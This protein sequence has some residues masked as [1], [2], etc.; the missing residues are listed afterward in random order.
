MWF[1]GHEHSLQVLCLF[2]FS[3]LA[4]TSC[5]FCSVYWVSTSCQDLYW[6]FPHIS[7]FVFP[8]AFH[9]NTLASC[10][11]RRDW[12]QC[13]RFPD[14]RDEVLPTSSILS[15]E[16]CTGHEST[17]T[18]GVGGRSLSKSWRKQYFKQVCLTQRLV[19][20]HQG[21][22]NSSPL[23]FNSHGVAMAPK[24]R[25]RVAPV[26]MKQISHLSK[27]MNTDGRLFTGMA[28]LLCLWVFVCILTVS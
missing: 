7:Y 2:N 22:F 21:P 23:Y 19:L 15:T 3:W 20:F 8:G 18:L 26:L 10:H 28:E 4:L 25:H 6:A 13:L 14:C 11:R 1:T 16:P 27:Q 24:A 5:A 17:D 9:V 12:R